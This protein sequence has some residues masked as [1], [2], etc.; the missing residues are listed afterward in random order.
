MATSE[1]RHAAYEK[2]HKTRRHKRRRK[3][4]V[5]LEHRAQ[6]FVRPAKRDSRRARRADAVLAPPTGKIYIDVD[7]RSGAAVKRHAARWSARSAEMMVRYFGRFPVPDLDVEIRRSG[8]GGVGFGQHFGGESVV[9]RVGEGADAEDL[10]RDWV[11]PHEMFHTAF[12]SLAKRHRWM[13]EGLSTYLESVIRAQAGVVSP[14]SVWRRWDDRLE[15]GLPGPGEGG[16]E[17]TRSWGSVY[18]GGTFFWFLVDVRLR[19]ETNNRVSLQNAL[20]QILASGG[21]ARK[22]WPIEKVIRAGDRATGTRVFSKTYQDVGLNP[23]RGDVSTLFDK[24]GVSVWGADVTYDETAPWAHVAKELLRQKY[25]LN[26]LL[27]LD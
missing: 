27:P 3:P 24:L 12:P 23:Y 11:L 22:T 26:A 18:W 7:R 13:R 5:G 20:V 25:D 8:Y 6:P 17:N 9:I 14:E 1:V 21:R 4:R 2:R 15:V 10:R 19:V 16:L